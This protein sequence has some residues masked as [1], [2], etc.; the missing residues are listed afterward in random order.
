MHRIALMSLCFAVSSCAQYQWVNYSNPNSNLQADYGYCQNEA[1]RV[2]PQTAVAPTPAPVVVQQPAS[3]T[4]DTNCTTQGN[5][6]NCATTTTRSGVDWGAASAQTANI[7]AQQAANTN[8]QA[9]NQN[10]AYNREAYAMNCLASR[11][12]GK[13][14]VN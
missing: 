11:G 10:T 1:M 14:R 9:A 5:Q 3:R 13:Q 7:Y 4:Y 12:W 2:V 8:Q 6:T